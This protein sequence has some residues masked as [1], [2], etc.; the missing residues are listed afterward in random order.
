MVLNS[1]TSEKGTLMPPLHPSP[2][3]RPLNDNTSA[4]FAWHMLV[5]RECWKQFTV[6]QQ[7]NKP[8]RH[9]EILK[10]WH[11]YT[12]NLQNLKTL[13]MAGNG[14]T[15]DIESAS[16]ATQIQ[17]LSLSHNKLSGTL[18]AFLTNITKVDLSYN[19]FSGEEGEGEGEDSDL[20]S[21]DMSAS[22]ASE[23]PDGGVQQQAAGTEIS[24]EINRLSGH[25]PVL[26]L[27]SAAENSSIAVLRGNMFSCNSIP[28]NDNFVND[29]ICGSENLNESLYVFATVFG[30]GCS[31]VVLYFL[32]T[33]CAEGAF[34]EMQ[35]VVK[36][37]QQ[38]WTAVSSTSYSVMKISPTLQTI[39]SLTDSFKDYM[40]FFLKLL[41]LTLSVSVL[42]YILKSNGSFTTHSETYAWFWTLA[43]MS[44]VVPAWL[45]VL[46]WAATASMCFYY[47]IL[48]PPRVHKRVD[49]APLEVQKLRG[50]SDSGAETAAAAGYMARM[51]AYL[52]IGA[53]LLLNATVTITVNSLYIYSTQQA[54]GALLHFI[55][56]LLM[57]IYRL[58]YAEISLPV[59]SKNI[60]N[61]VEN[62]T[63]RLK[64]L[65]LNNLLVPFIAT[66]LTSPACFQVRLSSSTDMILYYLDII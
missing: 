32:T 4:L 35:F 28:Q 11:L 25:L 44:G 51:K 6:L 21:T 9:V 54:F 48:V 50:V 52:P 63:F 22:L 12:L 8:L 64:L 37:I 43:Y 45:I 33:A 20:M 14:L 5:G 2:A 39:L 47:I 49:S 57:A 27:E 1:L 17:D 30:L 62:V 65:M 16:L 36:E 53:A 60:K 7:Q 23:D 15:G 59:L 46:L 38:S 55:I 24:F 18:P 66:F 40:L 56:Q 26:E 3:P 13:H 34:P 61:P 29:Y 10:T 41:F 58:I 31:A 19:Q 42:L